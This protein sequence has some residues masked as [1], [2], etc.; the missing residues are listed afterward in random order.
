MI[1]NLKEILE[2]HK[3][4]LNKE[5]GGEQ[6][7]LSGA[8]LSGAN[9]SGADIDYSVW[10]LWCGSLDVKVDDKILRQLLYHVLSVSQRSKLSDEL[11]NSLFTPELIREANK[12]HRV[13]EC[14]EIK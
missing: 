1:E 8:H 13:S 2:K 5:E 7:N 9:L 10:P 4:W 6:A 3:K 12:F 11:K 14:G